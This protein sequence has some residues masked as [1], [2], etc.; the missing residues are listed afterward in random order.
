MACRCAERTIALR[1]AV[2]AT[3]A[4]DLRQAAHQVAFAGRT[5]AQDARN[6]SLKAAAAQRLAVMRGR[7][8][9]G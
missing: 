8:R 7:V 9:H 6:G 4:G 3:R 1:Q 5:F 2:A